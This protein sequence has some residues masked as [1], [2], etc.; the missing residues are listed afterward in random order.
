[1]KVLERSEKIIFYQEYSD[2]TSRV[3][4][5]QLEKGKLDATLRGLNDEVLHQDDILSKLNKEKKHLSET[6]AK[7]S[8]ELA[9][10]QDKLDHLNDVKAKLEKTMDQMDAALESETYS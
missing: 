2:W 7:S 5:A 10:N 1:M 9:N 3:E 8:D 4:K 6:L